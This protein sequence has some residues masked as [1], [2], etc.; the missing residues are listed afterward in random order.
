ME[1]RRKMWVLVEA[2]AGIPASAKLFDS[3]QTAL[4]AEEK[5]REKM[6]P[7]NDETGVFPVT[8]RR[9]KK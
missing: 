7:E 8:V 4:K 3:R 2:E 5:M 6:H 1:T 9:P